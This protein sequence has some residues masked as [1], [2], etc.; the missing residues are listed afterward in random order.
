[1]S[2]PGHSPIARIMGGPAA[3]LAI[4]MDMAAS[5][6]PVPGA[7]VIYTL[8]F[9]NYGAYT[10]TGVLITDVVPAG[11]LNPLAVDSPAIT[12][13]GSLSFTWQVDSL[14]PGQ[15][16]VITL[17]GVLSPSLA[18][19]FVFTNTACISNS[20]LPD[21]APANNQASQEVMVEE[22]R[23]YLPLILKEQ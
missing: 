12:P 23:L 9:T 17:S 4:T 5:Q 10:A 19:G 11:L 18:P 1:M 7:Q 22:P 14:A 8:R 20:Q 2:R 21:F 15:V 16:G 13:T 3:D 6:A